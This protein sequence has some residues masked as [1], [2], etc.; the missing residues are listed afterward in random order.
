MA[1]GFPPLALTSSQ[2]PLPALA[3]TDIKAFV[4]QLDLRAHHAAHQDVA[5]PVVDGILKGTQL[6]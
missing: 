6:S 2:R 4:D 1:Y 5:N 3:D